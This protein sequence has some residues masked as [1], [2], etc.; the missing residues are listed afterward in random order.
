MKFPPDLGSGAVVSEGR[1]HRMHIQYYS[2]MEDDKP[3]TATVGMR[4][5]DAVLMNLRQ[6]RVTNLQLNFWIHKRNILA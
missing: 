1:F 3:E 5:Y 2:C 6:K 4:V